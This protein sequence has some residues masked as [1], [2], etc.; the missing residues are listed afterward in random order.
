[1]FI[2]PYQTKAASF[3]PVDK[4]QSAMKLAKLEN[5]LIPATRPIAGLTGLYGPTKDNNMWLLVKGP[6]GNDAE[7]PFNN[8]ITFTDTLGRQNI[9]IDVRTALSLNPDNGTIELRNR[10]AV[11]ELQQQIIRMKAIWYWMSGQHRDFL[12]LSPVPMQVFVR[13][14]AEGLSRKLNIGY[15]MMPRFMAYTCWFFFCQFYNEGEL[16]DDMRFDGIRKVADQGRVRADIVSDV[17]QDAPYVGTMQQ[18]VDNAYTVVGAEELRQ[19]DLRLFLNSAGGAWF[20][21]NAAESGA[22]GLEYPPVFLSMLYGSA[23]NKFYRNSVLGRILDRPEFKKTKEQ[24][25]RSFAG[26]IDV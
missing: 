11:T 20:G 22:I 17:L 5:R 4:I 24:F 25:M 1:M 18:F 6:V 21:A 10:N 8:P 15:D 3:N 14:V 26:C 2:S 9:V 23:E 13:W 19:L 12:N 7:T 16:N